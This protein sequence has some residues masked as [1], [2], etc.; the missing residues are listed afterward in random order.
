MV[1]VSTS[2]LD[3]HSDA[4]KTVQ[5]LVEA[6]ITDIELG[7]SHS[8]PIDIKKNIKH[9]KGIWLKLYSACILSSDKRN[10]HDEFW[11]RKQR[12]S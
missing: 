10:L 1:F 8:Y 12:N 2:S 5:R 9:E 4:V 7:A 6:G 3:E 11:F